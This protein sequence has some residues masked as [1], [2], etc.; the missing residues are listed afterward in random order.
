MGCLLAHGSQ[1][2]C[3]KGGSHWKEGTEIYLHGTV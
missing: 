2:I 3:Y 1:Y